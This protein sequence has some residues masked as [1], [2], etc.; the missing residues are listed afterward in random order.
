[1]PGLVPAIYVL[2]RCRQHVDAPD[3]PEPDEFPAEKTRPAAPG[4]FRYAITSTA[5]AYSAEY[6][7]SRIAFISSLGALYTAWSGYHG[8]GFEA[9]V[10]GPA[11]PVVV[12]ADGAV[13]VD[14]VPP[15]PVLLVPVAVVNTT[16]SLT[17][18]TLSNGT[19]T[20]C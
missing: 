4:A 19:A 10:P 1:M 6:L 7:N 13:E 3:K 2:N 17:N 5:A 12:V 18:F 14:G 20:R 15:A 9:A 16:G 11:E 8:L